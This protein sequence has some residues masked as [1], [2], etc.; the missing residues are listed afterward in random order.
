MQ[1]SPVGMDSGPTSNSNELRDDDE[2]SLTSTAASESQDE[3]E[4]ETIYAEERRCGVKTYLVKWKGYSD[5]RC[6]WEPASSFNGNDCLKNWKKKERAIKQGTDKPFNVQAWE[7]MIEASEDAKDE[8]K[9]RRREKRARLGFLPSKESA[10]DLGSSKTKDQPVRPVQ[11]VSEAEE[12]SSASDDDVPLVQARARSN[13]PLPHP[14]QPNTPH[15]SH[16]ISFRLKERDPAPEKRSVFTT[17]RPERPRI[18]APEPVAITMTGDRTKRRTLPHILHRAKERRK[19]STD[20]NKTW[21]LYSTSNKFEKATRQD[22]EPI[23][24]QLELQKPGDWTPFQMSSYLRGKQSKENDSL[25]VEQDDDD[26]DD[27]MNI[28]SPS[29]PLLNSAHS[30]PILTNTTFEKQLQISPVKDK[31]KFQFLSKPPTGPRLLTSPKKIY[32]VNSR[33]LSKKSDLLCLLSYGSDEVDV[34]EV[35][36]RDVSDS[37]RRTI[38]TTKKVRN[39]DLSFDELCSLDHYRA[40]T[41]E[42]E[43]LYEIEITAADSLIYRQGTAFSSTAVLLPLVIPRKNSPNL[44]S[45]C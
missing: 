11:Q 18:A 4:V 13:T 28:D 5:L 12:E 30:S 14:S 36:L 9:R 8:R 33:E 23:Q 27:D 35:C 32:R 16:G 2:I 40:I 17:P 22:H 37:A 1:M 6:T 15:G 43:S 31:N 7:A 45:S 26:D 25:F 39:I 3:Y 24:G 29:T 44:A 34:G 10:Q 19:S 20:E 42:V 41:K 38:Y 21:K